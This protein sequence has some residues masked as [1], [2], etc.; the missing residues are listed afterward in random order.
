MGIIFAPCGFPI[1]REPDEQ[2]VRRCIVAHPNAVPIRSLDQISVALVSRKHFG[3]SGMPAT[4]RKRA[5]KCRW[6]MLFH[7]CH[8]ETY[9]SFEERK[10]V[11]QIC[12]TRWECA[13]VP[14]VFAR[15]HDYGSRGGVY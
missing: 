8:L 3:G 15:D 6:S 14:P 4:N 9:G 7:V 11:V 13:V 2:I 10:A 1:S 12:H 5:C